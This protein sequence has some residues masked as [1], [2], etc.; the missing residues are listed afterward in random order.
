M[1]KV[2][3]HYHPSQYELKRARGTALTAMASEVEV[4]RGRFLWIFKEPDFMLRKRV[5]QAYTK[6]GNVV[7]G[8]DARM[9][10][11]VMFAASALGAFIG[12]GLW[13]VLNR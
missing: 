4:A 10:F 8:S 12:Q 5:V 13:K 3:L 2:D 1:I 9:M 11:W 6:V 7:S